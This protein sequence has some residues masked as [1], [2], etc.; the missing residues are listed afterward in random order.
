MKKLKFCKA[1]IIK[2]LKFFKNYFS[3]WHARCFYS[4]SRARRNRFEKEGCY[5]RPCKGKR[6]SFGMWRQKQR[7]ESVTHTGALR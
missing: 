6:F 1:F 7:F 3:L 5:A 4:K 2:E